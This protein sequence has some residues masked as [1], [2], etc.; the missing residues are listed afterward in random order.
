[1]TTVS[2]RSLV[3]SKAGSGI[4][5][6][7]RQ[8]GKIGNNTITLKVEVET[9]VDRSRG[10]ADYVQKFEGVRGGKRGN[11]QSNGT[12]IFC[13]HFSSSSSGECEHCSVHLVWL[14]DLFHC[15]PGH[16]LSCSQTA[17]CFIIIIIIFCLAFPLLWWTFSL[18]CSAQCSSCGHPSLQLRFKNVSATAAPAIDLQTVK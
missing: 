18:V 3:L 4:E 2:S 7:N 8:T 14:F 5:T 16:R 11:W 10:E 17:K 13:S 6:N 12:L 15:V 1:M 9:N